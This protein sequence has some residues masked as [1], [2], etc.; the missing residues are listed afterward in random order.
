MIET[1]SVVL[2]TILEPG[3]ESSSG[4]VK[5]REI[6]SSNFLLEVWSFGLSIILIGSGTES[7]GWSRGT[8]GT[9]GTLW[10]LGALQ[11]LCAR[12][13]PH[14]VGT[15][16]TLWSLGSRCTSPSWRT[17]STHPSWLT[18]RT[19]CIA[20]GEGEG[21]T[22]MRRHMCWEGERQWCL[23]SLLGHPWHILWWCRD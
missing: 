7:S 16:V 10:P 3:V 20:S 15:W 1:V 14:F 9:F 4:A 8:F 23:S 19:Q 21:E 2:V 18:V 11:T 12:M 5:A 22:R 6:R 17:C 13:S